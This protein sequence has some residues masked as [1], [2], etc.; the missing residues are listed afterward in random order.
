MK[1]G[2]AMNTCSL[3][4][5]G[6]A[7][8]ELWYLLHISEPWYLLHISEARTVGV[9]SHGHYGG[10]GRQMEH[11][12]KDETGGKKETVVSPGDF[13]SRSYLAPGAPQPQCHQPWG[14]QL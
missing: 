9:S 11:S 3:G 7:V 5:K 2:S 12:C 1:R 6:H 4:T 10:I 8:P 14:F 13:L